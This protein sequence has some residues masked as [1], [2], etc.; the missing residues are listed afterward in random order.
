MKIGLIAGRGALPKH[1]IIGAQKAKIDID[2]AGISGF[3][4]TDSFEDIGALAPP[5]FF[6]LAE[7]G[8]ITKFFKS[9]DCSHICF[10]GYVD[11]PNFLSLKPDLKGLR[12]LPGAIKAA[13]DGDN[14][15]LSYVLKIFEDEGFEI[16][17]PQDICA[18]LLL[19]EGHLG[20]V[21]MTKAHLE[22]AQKACR[23][24]QEIGKMD[25]GQAA[26]VC[27][28][29]V[30]AVEAQ[31]GTDKMLSRITEL[32]ENLRGLDENSPSARAGVLAKMVKP[33]QERRVDLPV[34]GLET[35]KRAA[36]AGLAGIVAEGERAL[37][38]NETEL[39]EL[40]DEAGLFI[41]G[42]PASKIS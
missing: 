6:G 36:Q 17:S 9:R 16:I 39:V 18:H 12:R 8:K 31:E 4:E 20:K 33:G 3:A 14:A 37:G 7:F 1:V 34:I 30:L 11:R 32:P 19:R 22:D 25:I 15:L 29:V 2:I 10:A 21:K 26:I 38:L 35:V 24:A 27:R 41:A 5:E 40:A 42:L 28:G 13:Q 23:T